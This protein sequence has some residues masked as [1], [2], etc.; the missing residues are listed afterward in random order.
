MKVKIGRIPY[1]YPVPIVLVGANVQGKPNFET[2]G[3]VDLMG[4]NPPLVYVSSGRDHYTNQGILENG[5]FSINFANT[6]LLA[7]TDYCGTVSGR[8]VDKGALFDTFY[9]ELGTAPMIEACPVNIECRVIQEFS[10]Q[11]R[12]VFVAEVVQTYVSDE[13]V[14]EKDGRKAI[15]DL[16]H[17]DPILY[18]LDNRYYSIGEP[19]GIGYQEAKQVKGDER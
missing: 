9:G 4:I 1:V 15:A 13:F 8:D 18:A 10:I 3:D 5:A 2:I 17:L 11:H 6:R 14:A 16:T 19:I 12:Q 7:L